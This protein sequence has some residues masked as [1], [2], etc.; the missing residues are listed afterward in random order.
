MSDIDTIKSGH[1]SSSKF[2]SVVNGAHGIYLLG[3]V[4]EKQKKGKEAVECY[5]IALEKNPT[6]WVAFEKIVKISDFLSSHYESVA[7]LFNENKLLSLKKNIS[8]NIFHKIL[9]RDKKQNSNN[10]SKESL[11]GGTQSSHNPKKSGNEMDLEPINALTTNTSNT[12]LTNPPAPANPTNLRIETRYSNSTNNANV[13]NTG[14]ASPFTRYSHAPRDRKDLKRSQNLSGNQ[15]VSVQGGGSNISIGSGG[16]LNNN[17]GN[18]GNDNTSINNSMNNL[19]NTNKDTNSTSNNATNL[20]E[21]Y[22]L[23][24]I[25][26]KIGKA[27]Y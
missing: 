3:Q 7:N 14:K 11:G 25:L 22:N 20:E 4:Y 6:L 17:G 13:S 23:S 19:V 24:E 27:Y 9:F 10:N 8:M 2:D 1:L 15:N 26:T 5:K 16:N 18:S 12:V 21:N